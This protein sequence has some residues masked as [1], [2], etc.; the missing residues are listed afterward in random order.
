MHVD[1]IVGRLT[2][3]GMLYE[4][5]LQLQANNEYVL[6]NARVYYRLWYGFGLWD[7]MAAYH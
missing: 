3:T 6:P 1:V 5:F 2:C 7:I 4:C